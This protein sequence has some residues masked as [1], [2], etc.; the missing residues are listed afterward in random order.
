MSLTDVEKKILLKIARGTIESYVNGMEDPLPDPPEG[1]L[2]EERG[3]FV[4]L[5]K[6]GALRGCIGTFAADKP[7]YEVVSEMAVSAAAKDPRFTP[8][9]S[10]ELKEIDIEISAITP[11]REITDVEE[12][13][14]GRH[15]IYLVKGKHAGVLLPQVA[16][17]HNLDRTAF[18]EHTCMK[19]GLPKSCWKEGAK[20]LVFE[21]EIFGEG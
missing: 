21:A 2:T 15:G 18:L 12:I 6:G 20:I 5:H 7:L 3:A 13:E 10:D 17:E 1:S 14:T 11:L 19:A 4:S 8:V 9:A 16:T